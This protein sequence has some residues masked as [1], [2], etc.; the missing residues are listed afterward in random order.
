MAKCIEFNEELTSNT[1]FS[2]TYNIL[3]IS[4]YSTSNKI[5]K[6]INH[7]YTIILFLNIKKKRLSFLLVNN[8]HK[9]CLKLLVLIKH[10]LEHFLNYYK[11]FFFFF[12][13]TFLS[14]I[15]LIFYIYSPATPLY[16]LYYVDILSTS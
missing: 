11:D 9:S 13:I 15:Y 6:K 7:Y 5:I 14:I 12:Y 4:T 16:I 2:N 1:V 8:F 3:S 10:H